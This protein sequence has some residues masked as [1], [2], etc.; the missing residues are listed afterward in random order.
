MDNHLEVDGCEVSLEETFAALGVVPRG[1]LSHE[2]C[3]MA[4]A[5]E[6]VNPFYV[7][8]VLLG[9]VFLVTACAYSVMAY[10]ALSP[11]LARQND[12]HPLTEFL[13]KHGMVL[14]AIELVLLRWHRLRP[15]RSTA[16]ASCE[17]RLKTPRTIGGPSTRQTAEKRS[18]ILLYTA[19]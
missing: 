17:S 7:L 12:G 16:G 18:R 2:C 4:K 14:L 5:R 6:P 1:F 11:A 3:A 8:L 15:W 13:D 9:I 10:R 19:V